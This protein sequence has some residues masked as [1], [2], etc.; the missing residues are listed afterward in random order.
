[1]WSVWSC[2]RFTATPGCSG[3]KQTLRWLTHCQAGLDDIIYAGHSEL[4]GNERCVESSLVYPAPDGP[5]PAATA[6]ITLKECGTLVLNSL[7]PPWC[8]RSGG[9]RSL[10]GWWAWGCVCEWQKSVGAGCV[11]ANPPT[12]RW[13]K[14]PNTANKICMGCLQSKL[15]SKDLNWTHRNTSGGLQSIQATIFYFIFFCNK[16]SFDSIAQIAP[17]SRSSAR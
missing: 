16:V 10:Q 17:H 11:C 3:T 13:L 6:I 2:W 5:L 14:T 7:W 4:G 8:R 12:P 9:G 15:V 1:M